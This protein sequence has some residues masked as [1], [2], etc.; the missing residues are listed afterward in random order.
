MLSNRQTRRYCVQVVNLK[1]DLARQQ[2][3]VEDAEAARQLCQS[4]A[5]EME[6]VYRQ[7]HHLQQRKV[8]P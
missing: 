4:Q 7:L 6:D 3:A 2:H 8:R 1:W 5:E